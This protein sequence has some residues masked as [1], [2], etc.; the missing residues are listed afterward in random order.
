MRKFLQAISI[1]GVISALSLAASWTAI[2]L[3]LQHNIRLSI[4]CAA[5]AFGLDSLDGYVARRMGKA[6]ELGRQLDGMI[7]LVNYSVYAGLMTYVQLIPGIVGAFIG[8]V[9]VLFGVLRLIRFNTEGF[10]EPGD[11]RRYYRGIVTCHVS[12]AVIVFVLL[13]TQM[14][15]PSA[16]PAIVLITLSILQLSDIKTRKTGMLPFWLSVAVLLVIGAWLWLP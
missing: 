9:I 4:I 3:L 16:V 8:Y 10:V 7:D 6:S 12:L 14:Q 11:G 1:P 15:L 2:I 5:V 13:Q